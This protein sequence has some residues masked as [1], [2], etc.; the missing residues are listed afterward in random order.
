MDSLNVWHSLGIDL[1]SLVNQL[2][3]KLGGVV[4][5]DL[6][7]SVL[8]MQSEVEIVVCRRGYGEAAVGRGASCVQ[9][10]DGWDKREFWATVRRGLRETREVQ[11]GNCL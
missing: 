7:W 9:L 3:L 11:N 8:V 2:R 5:P 1:D 4:P 6:E 10:V